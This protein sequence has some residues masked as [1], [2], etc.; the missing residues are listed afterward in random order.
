MESWVVMA[1]V[2][3]EDIKVETSLGDWLA[4]IEKT[5]AEGFREIRT[6]VA[7]KADKAGVESLRDELKHFQTTTG[8]R[9]QKLEEEAHDRRV[10]EQSHQE[11]EQQYTLSRRQKWAIAGGATTIILSLALDVISVIGNLH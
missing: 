7:D 4:R 8:G 3:V 1:E 10:R 11:H 2:R 5:Q 6:L 9:L